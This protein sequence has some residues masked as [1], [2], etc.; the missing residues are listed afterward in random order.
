M[1]IFRFEEV[2]R[3]LV[4][5]IKNNN[6]IPTKVKYVKHRIVFIVSLFYDTYLQ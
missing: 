6:K 1:V 4:V 3:Y 2:C 5:K